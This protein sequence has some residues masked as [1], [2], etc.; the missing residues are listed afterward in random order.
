MALRAIKTLEPY[1]IRVSGQA[2][3][4]ARGVYCR[5][6]IVGGRVAMQRRGAAIVTRAAG[7][8]HQGGGRVG[9]GSYCQIVTAETLP[10]ETWVKL[11]RRFDMGQ[12][13][14]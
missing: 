4:R 12:I 2:S 3:R 10:P 8:Y 13:V 6:L 11:P 1:R 5:A 7:H 9:H 14:K